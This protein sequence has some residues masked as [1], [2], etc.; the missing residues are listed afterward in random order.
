[1]TKKN[2]L[3]PS[4]MRSIAQTDWSSA[5]SVKRLEQTARAAF[6]AL[7]VGQA[8]TEE[9]KTR[10]RNYAVGAIV[11]AFPRAD[12]QDV[13]SKV[14]ELVA[15]VTGDPPSNRAFRM[16]DKVVIERFYGHACT[17]KDKPISAYESTIVRQTP[18]RWMLGPNSKRW[19]DKRTNIVK[20]ADMNY[21]DR[22]RLA[23][24]AQ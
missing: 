18:T 16:G 15:R 7:M 9:A 8:G 11:G 17:A 20:P 14:E 1:M 2:T 21:L 5:E 13:R 22:A 4:V 19:I 10:A 6:V 24:G 23:D 3:S 12:R